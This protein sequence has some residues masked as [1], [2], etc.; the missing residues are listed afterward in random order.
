MK[1][2]ELQNALEIREIHKK[3]LMKVYTLA[4]KGKTKYY[5]I[6]AFHCNTT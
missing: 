1:I 6:K 2:I 4:G 5:K 3:I